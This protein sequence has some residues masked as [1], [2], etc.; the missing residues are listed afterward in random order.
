VN[1][2][3]Y[4]WHKVCAS[5][6]DLKLE[7]NGIGVVEIS[8]KNVCITRFEGGWY[9]FPQSCPH[10]GAPLSLGCIDAKGYVICPHHG[11]KFNIRN[12]KM[13]FDGGCI[14]KTY[15]VE[16]RPEGIFIGFKKES[17]LSW[18]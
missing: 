9:A 4:H 11:Y 6:N 18:L 10:A 13:A 12:G 2:R 3:K 17:F 15:P 14:L 16:V 8:G 5:E 1:S 7:E